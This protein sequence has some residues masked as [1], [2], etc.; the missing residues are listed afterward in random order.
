M[1]RQ[2]IFKNKKKSPIQRRKKER[3]SMLILSSFFLSTIYYFTYIQN[4]PLII[5][6]Y[7]RIN[8]NCGEEIVNE[9]FVNCTFEVNS[10]EESDVIA[11]IKARIKIR[12][13]GKGWNAKS[14]KKEYR[15]ELSQRLSVLDFGELI[16]HV[17]EYKFP[18]IQY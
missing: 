11:P 15:I 13:S 12:G 4:T 7:P 10:H 2:D 3:I 16:F 8:I 14:P 18:K 6:N 1:F 9:K 5:L 17:K